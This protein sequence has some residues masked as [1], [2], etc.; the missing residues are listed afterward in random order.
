MLFNIFIN[1]MMDGLEQRSGVQVPHG[2]RDQWSHSD[3]YVA[4]ALFADD[5]VGLSPTPEAAAVFCAR[6]TT[7]C[8]IHE[9]EVGI[10]KCGIMEFL[11]NPSDPPVLTETHPAWESL[12]LQDQPVPRVTDYKYLGL[13]ITP[14]LDVAHMVKSRRRLGAVSVNQLLPFLH[15]ST[16][17]VSMRWQVVQCVIIPRLLY[18]AEVYGMNRTLTDTMQTLVNRALRAILGAPVGASSVPSAPLWREFRTPPVCALAAARRARA[19]RKCFELTTTIGTTIRH[20][21]KARRWT[22]STGTVRWIRRYCAQYFPVVKSTVLSRRDQGKDWETLDAHSLRDLVQA[23]IQ[24]RE[25]EIRKNPRRATGRATIT[26]L[27]GNYSDRPLAVGRVFCSPRAHAGISQVMQCRIG[28]YPTAPVL[29]ESTRL[30]DLYNTVCPSCRRE[31][32]ETMYHLLFVCRAW[33][34]QRRDSGLSDVIRAVEQLHRRWNRA[35]TLHGP[36]DEVELLGTTRLPA[37]ALALS[38]ILGGRHDRRWGLHDYLPSAPTP[39][40][41]E[42]APPPSPSSSASEGSGE[43]GG[44]TRQDE[45]RAHL[46]KVGEFLGMITPLRW[47]ILSPLILPTP[48]TIGRRQDT[49][50]PASSTGQSPNG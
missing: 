40:D 5:A 49:G 39:R 28:C 47:R 30:P 2:P 25:T 45:V 1:D 19:Y 34:R 9:M 33:R 35:R 14:T 7:W 36:P 50:A 43:V 3:I 11:P 32:Q 26:Y 41:A 6:V 37:E 29:V 13:G 17:P 12:T 46:L 23:S 27:E 16:L 24:H 4:G 18:G 48:R 38:W 22:W 20:P 21:L 31:A 10:N 44:P 8:N 42:V 15:C